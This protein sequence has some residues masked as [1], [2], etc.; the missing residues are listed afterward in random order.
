MPIG[1]ARQPAF[2]FACP[3][4]GGEITGQFVQMLAR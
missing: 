1:F 3:S 2:Q 4:G